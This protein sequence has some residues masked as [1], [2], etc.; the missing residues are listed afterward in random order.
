MDSGKM[1]LWSFK[2]SKYMLA[3]LIVILTVGVGLAQETKPQPRVTVAW[4]ANKTENESQDWIANGLHYD[5]TRRLLRIKGLVVTDSP[6]FRRARS[7]LGLIKKDLSNPQEAVKIANALGSDK[8]LVG[9]Y[10]KAPTG[11]KVVVRLVDAKTGKYVGPEMSKTGPPI[12]VGASLALQVAGQFGIKLDDSTE[13][14]KNLTSNA[15]AYEHYCKGLQYKEKALLNDEDSEE[16]GEKAIEYF[17]QATKEDKDFA[18][19]HFELGWL[20]AL[21]GNEKGPVMYRLAV[22]EYKKAISLYPKY[23][24]AYNSLALM[25]WELDQEKNALKAYLKAV[26]LIPGYMDARFNLGTLY[27]SMKEY[28]K[29]IKEY[30]KVI[31]LNPTDAIV[32][33]NLAVALFNEGKSDEALKSYK[34]TLKLKPDLKEAHLGLGLIYDSKEDKERAMRHY[35]KYFDLG[36]FD[37]EIRERLEQLKARKEE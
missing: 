31:E 24:E 34:A 5:L 32:H 13:I 14:T 1:I 16:N 15:D 2:M 10:T 6:A 36:G 4:L 3:V 25:Y 37:D 17:I 7:E 21:K 11:I 33:N 9:N 26:E 35:Q 19:P 8:I 18:A 12:S 20:S 29:A 22:K 28:G 27:D 23:A 30:K